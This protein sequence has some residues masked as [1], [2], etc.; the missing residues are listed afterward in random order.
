MKE[1][2]REFDET[3]KELSKVRESMAVL[4]TLLLD[5]HGNILPKYK[6]S[7]F[8]VEI[9]LKCVQEQRSLICT[10]YASGEEG[11]LAWLM[12]KIEDR[13]TLK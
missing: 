1:V 9:A 4:S 13:H 10:G 3:Q 12:E 8:A 11:H 7:R 2:S 5:K 6:G